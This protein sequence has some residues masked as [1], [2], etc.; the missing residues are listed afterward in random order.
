M[1]GQATNV[2]K[3]DL[4]RVNGKKQIK[5]DAVVGKNAKISRR[6]RGHPQGTWGGQL[7]MLSDIII[8]EEHYTYV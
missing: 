4:A 6:Q 8:F 5:Y 2:L 3:L 7:L 1:F